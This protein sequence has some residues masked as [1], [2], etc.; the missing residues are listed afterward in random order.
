M[1]FPVRFRA[2]EDAE[3]V[4]AGSGM[5]ASEYLALVQAGVFRELTAPQPKVDIYRRELQ[6]AYID[7]LKAFTG[8][9]QRFSNF[10]QMMAS[11]FSSFSIDLRRLRGCAAYVAARHARRCASCGGQADAIASGATGSRDRA[12]FE[13][14][15]ELIR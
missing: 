8:D 6:R 1:L 4:K 12:D 15:R 10:N 14:S 9:V 5:V 2:L 11:A 3:M 7:Q 13:D